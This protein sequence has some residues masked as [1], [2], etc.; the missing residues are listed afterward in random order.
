MVSSG[1]SLLSSVS[2]SALP[3]RALIQMHTAGMSGYHGNDLTSSRA[4]SSGV[5]VCG[6]HIIDSQGLI[7]GTCPGC[8]ALTE[9]VLPWLCKHACHAHAV[10]LLADMLPPR[11]VSVATLF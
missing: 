4:P 8:P 6:Q 3:A 7:H 11:G 5:S 9:W 1:S 2:A 10:P